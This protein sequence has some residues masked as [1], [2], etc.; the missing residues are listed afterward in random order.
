ML[1]RAD[2]GPVTRVEMAT[3]TVLNAGRLR[4]E[5]LADLEC[6]T[7]LTWRS[8][9][10]SDISDL[11]PL[12]GW[13]AL[14]WLNLGSAPGVPASP[15]DAVNERM[16]G[17]RSRCLNTPVGWS[18]D[19]RGELSPAGVGDQEP[20][21]RLHAMVPFAQ[22]GQERKGRSTIALPRHLGIL[23]KACAEVPVM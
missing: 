17:R 6:A 9:E 8:I 15:R 10:D 3:L 4:I 18:P 2:D 19:G 13:T 20:A 12:A 23:G 14:T 7:G 16:G 22:V 5:S 21:H 11:S 1:N